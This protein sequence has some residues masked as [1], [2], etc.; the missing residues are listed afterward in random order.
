[1]AASPINQFYT[2]P[3]ARTWASSSPPSN[4]LDI[5]AFYN[6]LP[7]FAPTSL[8]PLPAITKELGLKSVYVKAETSR[9]GLPSFKLLG[10]SWAIRQA[11]IQRACL[12]SSASLDDLR[13]AVTQQGIKLC[14]ATDGNHGRAVARMGV[15]LGVKEVKIFVTKGLGESIVRS[16]AGEGECVDVRVVEGCY[17]DS[18]KV[19]HCWGEENKGGMLIEGTAFEGY[20]DV[21]KWTVQGYRTMLYEIDSQ[22]EGRVPS[23]V[24]APVGVGSLAQAIVTHYK[25]PKLPASCLTHSN[26]LQAP[27]P[28]QT[29]VLTVEPHAAASLHTSLQ[30]GTSVTVTTTSTIMTGLEC[31]TISTAAWPILRDGVDASVTVGDGEVHCA[32]RELEG[33]GVM[34]GPCGAA[35]LAGLRAVLETVNGERNEKMKGVLGLDEE[36]IVI[37]ICTEGTRPYV[38]PGM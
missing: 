33:Y 32:L 30:A 34:A 6:S 10:V 25:A 19:A 38:A 36:S 26:S 11:I 17:D 8:I 9:L 12:P 1:M 29:A 2:N 35:G 18:V 31:G 15:L 28:N 27:A 5:T 37:L 13:T 23:L 4:A 14:A 22:L 7:N 20:E 21:P 3:S 16:I 24:V